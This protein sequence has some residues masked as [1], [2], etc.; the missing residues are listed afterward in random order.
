ME[1]S[2]FPFNTLI[3][4]TSYGQ[5]ARPI[6][7]ALSAIHDQLCVLASLLREARK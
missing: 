5:E 2:V 4:M 7:I 3:D 1:D 6:C